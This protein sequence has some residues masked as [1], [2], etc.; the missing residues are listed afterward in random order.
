MGRVSEETAGEPWPGSQLRRWRENR[1]WTLDEAAGLTG[2]SKSYLSRIELGERLP[3]P[4]TKI[5]I[6]RRLGAGVA[7]LFPAG[8]APEEE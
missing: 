5:L 2:L 6:A 3:P 1:G 4:A 8:A 7:R